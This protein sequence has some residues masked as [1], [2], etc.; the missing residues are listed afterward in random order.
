MLPTRTRPLGGGDLPAGYTRLE[1]LES[2]GTQHINT[3]LRASNKTEIRCTHRTTVEHDGGAVRYMQLFGS[4]NN[5]IPKIHLT[6]TQSTNSSGVKIAT[7]TARFGT[8]SNLLNVDI[9]DFEI[10]ELFLSSQRLEC[11]DLGR[12]VAIKDSGEWTNTEDFLIARSF[13]GCIY[14]FTLKEAGELKL[15]LIPALDPAGRPCMFDTVSR[16]PFYNAGTGEFLY[17]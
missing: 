3:G 17:A 12:S 11:V 7:W 10:H 1:Y 16:K 4:Q 13:I 2:T 8:I 6:I 14:A 5:T 15:N 9:P